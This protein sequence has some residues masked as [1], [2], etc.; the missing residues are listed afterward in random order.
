MAFDTHAAGAA[1]AAPANAHIRIGSMAPT[2]AARPAEPFLD[3]AARVASAR[4][5]PRR[6]GVLTMRTE[7]R[8]LPIREGVS[9][10]V[11]A[12]GVGHYPGTAFPGEEGNAVFFGHR[13]TM[14]KPFRRIDRLRAGDRVR[15]RVGSRTYVY[16]V[17]GRRVIA[18][19]NRTVLA[20]VPFKPFARPAGKRATLITCHPK[21]SDAQRLVV[22]AKLDTGAPEPRPAYH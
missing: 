6:L 19:T 15:F 11:L 8:R 16:R 7:P 18:P 22:L 4:R 20:P 17:Y 13:T 3:A 9:P 10:D 14:T 21:G 5:A 2:A 12:R 1:T